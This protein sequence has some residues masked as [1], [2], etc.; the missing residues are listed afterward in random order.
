L[1][2]KKSVNLVSHEVN[3]ELMI[4]TYILYHWHIL[5]VMA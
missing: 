2:L 5:E 1:L 3:N 4:M